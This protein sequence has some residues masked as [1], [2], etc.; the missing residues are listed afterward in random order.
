MAEL[1]GVVA[2]GISIVTIAAQISSSVIK[3]KS[4]YDELNEAPEEIR[5]LIER[6]EILSMLLTQI[7]DD[8]GGNSLPSGTLDASSASRCLEN[9]LTGADRLKE[10][11][12]DLGA[13]VALSKGLKKKWIGFKVLLRKTKIDKFKN[14]LEGAIVLLNLSYQCYM[15]FGILSSCFMLLKD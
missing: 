2:S 4:Y 12:D 10:L 13:E 9:C 3:L 15:R 7:R 5:S 8:Q 1:L 14:R 11:V 6:V